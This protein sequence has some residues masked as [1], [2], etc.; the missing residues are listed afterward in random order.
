MIEGRNLYIP[1]YNQV[2]FLNYLISERNL[3]PEYENMHSRSTNITI[4]LNSCMIL[5]GFLFTILKDYLFIAEHRIGEQ[6]RIEKIDHPKLF[7]KFLLEYSSRLDDNGWRDYL[8]LFE[9]FTNCKIDKRN[10]HWNSVD[11]LFNYINFLV[12]GNE[13]DLYLSGDSISNIKIEP[14]NRKLN[15][16]IDYLK[17]TDLIKVDETKVQV[18]LLN[19]KVADHFYYEMKMFAIYIFE[20]IP[21]DHRTKTIAD[22]FLFYNSPDEFN[23]ISATHK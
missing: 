23:D 17:A 6:S 1:Y 7:K 11:V 2:Q 20:L 9:L 13:I 3:I 10:E 4:I 5:E 8:N 22:M 18:D 19:N 15:K 12:H 16:I 14:A 21:S